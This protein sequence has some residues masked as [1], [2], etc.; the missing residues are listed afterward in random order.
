MANSS[1]YFVNF[2]NTPTMLYD[3]LQT[4][5]ANR[6]SLSLNGAAIPVSGGLR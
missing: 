1:H 4:N 5:V 2:V 6:L 3:Q